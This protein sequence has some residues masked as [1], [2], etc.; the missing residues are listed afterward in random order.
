[1]ILVYLIPIK[2][3]MWLIMY[4]FPQMRK[5]LTTLGTLIFS[6]KLHG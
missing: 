2:C 5:I 3:T 1:M 6:L 4:H